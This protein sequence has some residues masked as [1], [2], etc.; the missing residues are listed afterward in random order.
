MIATSVK[1]SYQPILSIKDKRFSMYHLQQYYLTIGIGDTSFRICCIDQVANRCLLLEAYRLDY[2][3]STERI[4][5][6]EQLYQERPLLAASAWDTV[7]LCI[8]NQQYTLIPKALFQEKNTADYLKLASPIGNNTVQHFAHPQLDVVV[9]FAVEPYL[10]GWFQKTYEQARLC[11]MHQ[12]SSLIEG[13]FSYLKAERLE[14]SPRLFVAAEAEHVHITVIKKAMLRYYNRF[15]YSNSDEFL[16][17]ILIVMYTLDLDPSVTKVILGGNVTK[18]SLAY[19]KACNYIPKVIFNDSPT[20][21]KF[22][23]AFRKSIITNYF[24][25]LSAHLP[26][27]LP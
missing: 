26:Q 17:Y 12:A 3:S 24:D 22:R 16:Q 11:V 15:S 1:T 10:L 6:L 13:V 20:H 14:A 4:S 2:S 23:R 5:A 9:T 7:I 21:L 27:E 8:E 25:L 18:K 19:R